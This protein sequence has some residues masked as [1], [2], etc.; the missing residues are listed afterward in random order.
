MVSSRRGLAL[1]LAAGACIAGAGA[2]LHAEPE[3]GHVFQ[4]QY[5]GASGTRVASG[6]EPLYFNTTVYAEEAVTTEGGGGTALRFHDGTKLQVGA[7]SRVVL[8]RFVYDP[9]AGGADAL[10]N[11]SQG[12]FRFI[13]G[14]LRGDAM[15]LETPSATLAIRGTKFILAVDGAG[16]TGVWVIDGAVEAMSRA[17]GAPGTAREG[18]S[19]QVLSGTPGVLVS[20]GRTAPRDP[21]VERDLPILGQQQS[22]GGGDH[23]SRGGRSGGQ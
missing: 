18:Q 11:F 8:D 21:A 13:S 19:L 22:G 20:D 23:P 9:D 6:S 14:E 16:N 1:L 12:I 5:L 15:R 17:G 3:I 10:L 4:R 2:D 7:E